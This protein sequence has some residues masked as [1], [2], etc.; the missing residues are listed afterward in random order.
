MRAGSTC[1]MELVLRIVALEGRLGGGGIIA[2]R[3]WR[4][5]FNGSVISLQVQLGAGRWKI[6]P[7]DGAQVPLLRY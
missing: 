1:A 6:L 4:C 7:A 2:V 5:A 3:S